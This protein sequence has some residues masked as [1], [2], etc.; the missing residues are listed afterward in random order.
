MP[1]YE[2]GCLACG[3]QFEKFM[4]VATAVACPSC[5]SDRVSRNNEGARRPLARARVG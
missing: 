5:E 2:Y 1:I 3:A 4:Q